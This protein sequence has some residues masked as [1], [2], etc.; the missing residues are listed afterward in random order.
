MANYTTNQGHPLSRPLN[1][2]ALAGLCG[3]LLFAFVWQIHFDEPPCP[4]CRQGRHL[5]P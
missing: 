2:L 1:C 4:L 3:V 5:E